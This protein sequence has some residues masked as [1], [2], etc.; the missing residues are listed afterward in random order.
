MY[1]TEATFFVLGNLVAAN[2]ELLADPART[3][4]VEADEQDCYASESAADIDNEM[5][6]FI[7]VNFLF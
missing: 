1:V 6:N 7:V 3:P 4:K 2:F 5:L